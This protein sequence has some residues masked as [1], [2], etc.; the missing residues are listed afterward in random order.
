MSDL[1][2]IFEKIAPDLQEVDQLILNFS[3]GK[4]PLIKEISH[5]LI[6]SGGKRIRP[7]L[8]ILSA[9]LCQLDNDSRVYNLACAVELIHSATLLHDDVVDVSEIRRGKKTASAIWDNKFSILVGD[10]LFATAFEQMVK[11]N[12]MQALQLLAKTSAIIADG[13]VMQL[14]NSH[15]LGINLDKYLEIIMAKT[16][17]LFSASTE[18]GAIISNSSDLKIKALRN[19]GKNLGMVFQIIDDILDYTAKEQDLGKDLGNDFFEGK[20]TLPI[21]YTYQNASN[22]Q[23]EFIKKKFSANFQNSERDYEGLKQII[24]LFNQY[25]A[26]DFC[27]AKAIEFCDQAKK[28]LE[29]FESSNYRNDLIKILEYSLQRIS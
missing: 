26:I 8:L 6:K 3:Q 23:K 21:I 13:E 7:V 10:F 9:K 29:V 25:Q 16:A 5:H 28:D 15:D 18:I 11:S 17:I 20:V 22:A 24:D 27:K 1:K 14:E 12:N 4:S 19:F 2:E